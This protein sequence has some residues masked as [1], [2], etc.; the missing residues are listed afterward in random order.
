V[1]GVSTK[2]LAG[3]LEVQKICRMPYKENERNEAKTDPEIDMQ[4][5]PFRFNPES[6]AAPN[7]QPRQS[8]EKV[9]LCGFL[10][11]LCFLYWK[12]PQ[13]FNTI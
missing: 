6:Q 11:S 9:K 1:S 7:P 13:T 5:E 8:Q 10:N 4:L 3:P 12:P 2:K